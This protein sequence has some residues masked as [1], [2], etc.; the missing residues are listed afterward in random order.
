MYFE[1]RFS[2]IPAGYILGGRCILCARMGPVD[3]HLIEERHGRT[4]MLRHVD[5]KLRCRRCGNGVA[6]QFVVYGR[7]IR[8]AP[9]L[10]TD[11]VDLP[12]TDT[13]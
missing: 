5:K 6:N 10:P 11:V 8:K 3:R 13:R 2:D 7:L 4:T 12:I 9:Q 1:I